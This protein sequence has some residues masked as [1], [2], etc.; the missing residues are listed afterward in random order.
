MFGINYGCFVLGRS[1][2]GTGYISRIAA[3]A[4]SGVVCLGFRL[5][6]CFTVT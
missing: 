1:A 6:S 5:G 3:I 2:T 4:L